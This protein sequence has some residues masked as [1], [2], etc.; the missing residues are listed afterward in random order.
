M[1]QVLPEIM[2]MKEITP[3]IPHVQ[4]GLTHSL[5]VSELIRF[6]L[7]CILNTEEKNENKFLN[8]VQSLIGNY[9][10]LN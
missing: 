6:F 10:S 5:R 3:R 2:N 7:D 4:D 9:N 1:A 8:D